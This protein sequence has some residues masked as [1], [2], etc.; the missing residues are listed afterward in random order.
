M[1]QVL[2]P[3][4][5]EPIGNVAPAVAA[6]DDRAAESLAGWRATPASRRAAILT[7]AARRLRADA[8]TFAE[9]E[10]RN[11]GKNLHD[12]RREAERAAGVHVL[13]ARPTAPSQPLRYPA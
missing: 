11:V 2:A 10:A 3:A 13:A 9:I 6:A 7:E 12:T 4:T 5:G 1:T 8:E